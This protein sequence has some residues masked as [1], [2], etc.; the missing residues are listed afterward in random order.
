MIKKGVQ[1]NNRKL[2]NTILYVDDQILMATSEDDL[3]T[4][5]YRLILTARKH[6]MTRSSTKTK[7]MEMWGNH[8]QR[9]QIV[10]NDS[11]IEQVTDFKYLG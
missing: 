11:I 2:V 1:L 9:V 4:V 6:K 5:A 7:A 3:Q 8:I 10:I